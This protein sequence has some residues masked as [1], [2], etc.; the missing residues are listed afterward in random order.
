M[1]PNNLINLRTKLKGVHK[2]TNRGLSASLTAGV[3]WEQWGPHRGFTAYC[4]VAWIPM[5]P[6]S[7]LLLSQ[8]KMVGQ[9]NTIAAGVYRALFIGYCIYFRHQRRSGASLRI[10]FENQER[11]KSLPRRE[12]DF[13]SYW[14]LKMPKLF[15]NSS[16]KNSC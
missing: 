6:S 8:E 2:I 5:P 16:L 4:F 1:F 11:N 15:R 14:T 7:L 13:S 12:L 9:N 10:G 3:R